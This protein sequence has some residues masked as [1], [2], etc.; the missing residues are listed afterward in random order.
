MNGDRH[1][2]RR[3][4]LS[5]AFSNPDGDA[6]SDLYTNQAEVDAGTDPSDVFSSPDSDDDGLADGFEVFYFGDSAT[7]DLATILP[8]QDADGDPD[9]D[10]YLNGAEAA[11]LPVASDPND[12]NLTPLDTDTDGDGLIDGWENGNF[13]DLDEVATVIPTG[14]ARTMWP[15]SSR[16]PTRTTVPP[17]PVI[18]MATES[19]MAT[20]RCNPTPQIRTRFISGI[21][22]NWRPRR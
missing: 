9:V 19:P 18:V 3:P 22:M 20:K 5:V 4:E 17:R 1:F 7:E 14:T 15:S 6:D 10:G 2:S 11:A 16:A 13:M 21:S 12:A 8:R